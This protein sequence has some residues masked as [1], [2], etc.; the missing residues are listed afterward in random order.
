V[1][2]RKEVAGLVEKKT[3]SRGTFKRGTS[4]FLKARNPSINIHIIVLA[5]SPS[6]TNLF[7]DIAL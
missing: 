6:T 3:N 4:F 1:K 5:Q 7:R 2:L